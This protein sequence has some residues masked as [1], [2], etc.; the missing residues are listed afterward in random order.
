MTCG[1]GN[2]II[3][4]PGSPEW[5]TPDLLNHT[6]EVWNPYYDEQLTVTEALDILMAVSRLADAV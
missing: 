6:L 3:V 5:V 2:N 4:P 1:S